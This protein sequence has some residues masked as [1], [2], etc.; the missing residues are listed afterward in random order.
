MLDPRQHFV[1]VQMH[2]H[3]LIAAPSPDYINFQP[4]PLQLQMPPIVTSQ[5]QTAKYRM[6]AFPPLQQQKQLLFVPPPAI[7]QQSF[8]CIDKAHQL[9][10]GAPSQQ[11][12]H[13]SVQFAHL[14]IQHQSIVPQ[15]HLTMP[16]VHKPPPCLQNGQIQQYSPLALSCPQGPQF[17]A[18][19]NI[20]ELLQAPKTNLNNNEV[21]AVKFQLN[22]NAAEFIPKS[23]QFINVS[24][25]KIEIAIE[26]GISDDNHQ[27]SIESAEI[28][29]E[30]QE[31]SN[32][33]EEISNMSTVNDIEISSEEVEEAVGLPL[34]EFDE[35]DG[36][37]Q[38]EIL[39]II[40]DERNCEIS[41]IQSVVVA[42]ES[43]D[44]D[45]AHKETL[46]QCESPSEIFL[47]TDPKW[48]VAMQKIKDEKAK[49]LFPFVQ[50]KVEKMI[51]KPPQLED[52][53][54][55]DTSI[56]E[57]IANIYGFIQE[58][59]NKDDQVDDNFDFDANMSVVERIENIL[60][61]MKQ[62][63][64]EKFEI[65]V[66]LHLP[67]GENLNYFNFIFLNSS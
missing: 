59:E 25:Q 50:R 37:T 56:L 13:A 53:T 62:K 9:T 17:N 67:T 6:S 49:N 43:Q 64:E 3:Q 63:D 39:Q 5:Q 42:K 65:D 10:S 23:R 8:S 1:Y 61:R 34:P 32:E 26:V 41:N 29:D 33:C 7:Q 31:I 44:D 66:D 35:N 52:E 48:L 40:F 11:I 58:E 27:D 57:S 47:E 14:A 45:V 22:P 2:P 24:P 36:L 19:P 55:S 18:R 38:E 16:V 12:L 54:D 20:Q 21:V 30:I 28:S 4:P 60:N 51:A 46:P 15:Q